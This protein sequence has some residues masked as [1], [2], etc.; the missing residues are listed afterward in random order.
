MSNTED[1]SDRIINADALDHFAIIEPYQDIG[2][3]MHTNEAEHLLIRMHTHIHT[4]MWR[5]LAAA[6]ERP[7]PGVGC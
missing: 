6:E 1:A 4:V 3:R 7:P 5:Q 2:A